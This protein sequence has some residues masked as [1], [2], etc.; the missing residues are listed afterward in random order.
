GQFGKPDV[1]GLHAGHDFATDLPDRRVVVTEQVRSHFF[2]PRRAL[3]PPCPHEGDVPTDILPQE[4][5]G[6]EQVVLVVLLEDPHARRRTQRPEMDGRWIHRGG[7]VHVMQVGY[8]TSELEV[9]N[10]PNERDVR[11]VNGEGQLYLICVC[12]RVE[13]L[14]LRGSSGR[15][16]RSVSGGHNCA[17]GEYERREPEAPAARARRRGPQRGTHVGVAC[18]GWGPGAVINVG[19]REPNKHDGSLESAA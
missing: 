7:D 6:L 16:Q 13:I 8:S 2:F 10:V 4:L 1:V 14:R 5:L 18:R 3:I 17:Y 15:R 12:R 11:V 19:P 9:A